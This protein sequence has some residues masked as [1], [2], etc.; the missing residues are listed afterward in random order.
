MPCQLTE[1]LTRTLDCQAQSRALS[2][3]ISRI[4]RKEAYHLLVFCCVVASTHSHDKY[5]NFYWQLPTSKATM[6]PR[7]PF[8]M[9]QVT[10]LEPPLRLRRNLGYIGCSF[11]L[12][13][14]FSIV[15][16]I[17]GSLISSVRALSSTALLHI[18]F[19]LGFIKMWK[20][21]TNRKSGFFWDQSQLVNSSHLPCTHTCSSQ[22][23]TTITFILLFMLPCEFTPFLQACFLGRITFPAFLWFPMQSFKL[24]GPWTL[25]HDCRVKMTHCGIEQWW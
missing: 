14:N 13:Q 8:K 25:I 6:A 7:S 9:T 24:V 16:I 11:C 15:E 4:D 22:N 10:F 23:G 2:T 3:K 1:K 5:R 18:P 12:C 21:L 20:H 17:L 19:S